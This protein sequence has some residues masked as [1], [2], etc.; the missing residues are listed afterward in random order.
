M[1]ENSK[2]IV[3]KAKY[4][5]INTVSLDFHYN[6][7]FDYSWEIDLKCN[8]NHLLESSV[9]SKECPALLVHVL[10]VCNSL[11]QPLLELL[12]K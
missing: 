2:E 8:T 4:R 3:C 10:Y 5:E 9:Y 1:C 6:F 11:S 7:R 12:V